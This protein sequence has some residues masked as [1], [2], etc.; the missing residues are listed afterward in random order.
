MEGTAGVEMPDCGMPGEV[1]ANRNAIAG[2]PQPLEIAARFPHSH[3][4]YY[5]VFLSVFRAPGAS[6][7][8]DRASHGTALT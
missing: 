2:I 1:T 8:G 6:R 7:P 4:R 5:W 3:P